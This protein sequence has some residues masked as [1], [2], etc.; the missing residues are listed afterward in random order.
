M[1]VFKELEDLLSGP[2][3]SAQC[4][5]Q[6][7]PLKRERGY[8]NL[9]IK[10]TELELLPALPC[11]WADTYSKT[12]LSVT[13]PLARLKQTVKSPTSCWA[14]CTTA[15]W[16]CHVVNSATHHLTNS[17]TNSPSFSRVAKAWLLFTISQPLNSSQVAA[18]LQ[19]RGGSLV[20]W[21]GGRRG[22]RDRACVPTCPA[23]RNTLEGFFRGS[24]YFQTRKKK[25]PAF[26]VL[27]D[28]I[29][30]QK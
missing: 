18:G 13:S 25:N 6:P 7:L 28:D 5:F 22:E 24:Q 27:G 30:L 12:L 15:Y 10:G 11:Y 2:S 9:K 17:R 29:S 8:Q 19:E 1:A 26:V 20:R 4:I 16:R 3:V 21:E 23:H 14:S